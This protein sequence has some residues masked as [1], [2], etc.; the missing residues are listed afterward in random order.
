MVR[1]GSNKDVVVV[2]V[3]QSALKDCVI[4]WDLN[5][6]LELDSFDVDKG[7]IFFQD[8]QGNPFLAEKD[9]IL[10]CEKGVRLKCYDFDINDFEV[11][12]FD[13]STGNRVETNTHNWMVFRNFINLSFSY[14]TFV[15]KD[16]VA[17]NYLQP[18]FLF[19]I[20]GYDFIY[21]RET[22]FTDDRNLVTLNYEKL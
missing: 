10:M 2:R 3:A 4:M 21:N 8:E 5:K 13:F 17:E 9:Y 6:D 19:D 22:V 7:S 15:V 12:K 14:M 11:P 18:D 1:T 16:N 20:E